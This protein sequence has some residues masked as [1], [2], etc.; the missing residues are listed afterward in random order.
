MAS[1]LSGVSLL[2]STDT[3]ASATA[4]FSLSRFNHTARRLA[5]YA[6]PRRSPFATQDSLPAGGI[7]WP[8]RTAHSGPAV[9]SYEKFPSFDFPFPQASLGA[10]C[11]PV[12]PLSGSWK[13]RSIVYGRRLSSVSDIGGTNGSLAIGGTIAPGLALAGHLGTNTVGGHFNGGPFTHANITSAMRPGVS[14]AASSGAG[15]SLFELGVLLDWIGRATRRPGVG[16]ASP[17]CRRGVSTE[18]VNESETAGC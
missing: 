8:D 16:H 17:P 15:V 12:N 9:G 6:S 13:I 18:S 11:L 4:L 3:T 2:P 1:L 10:P 5:V 7:P 14:T